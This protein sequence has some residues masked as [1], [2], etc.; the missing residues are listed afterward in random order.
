MN[1]KLLC[2]QLNWNTWGMFEFFELVW[3]FKLVWKQWCN[4]YDAWCNACKRK[5]TKSNWGKIPRVLQT[6]PL[7]R[8]CALAIRPPPGREKKSDYRFFML[9]VDLLDTTNKIFSTPLTRASC[10]HRRRCSST[11]NLPM[12]DPIRLKG[13]ENVHPRRK[14][15]TLKDREEERLQNK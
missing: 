12:I 13:S 1:Y 2:L 14:P 7:T 11:K 3:I 15:N 6:T 5:T 8:D 9:Q 4:A 10:P